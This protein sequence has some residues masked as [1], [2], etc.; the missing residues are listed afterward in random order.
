MICQYEVNMVVDSITL[1]LFVVYSPLLSEC[2]ID[3]FHMGLGT[4]WYFMVLLGTTNKLSIKWIPCLHFKLHGEFHSYFLF[5]MSIWWP[6]YNMK[7]SEEPC[8]KWKDLW[9]SILFALLTLPS[10]AFYKE[11]LLCWLQREIFRKNIV[12]RICCVIYIFSFVHLMLAVVHGHRSTQPNKAE[13][14]MTSKWSQRNTTNKIHDLYLVPIYIY[15]LKQAEIIQFM[16]NIIET[17]QSPVV[18][19]ILF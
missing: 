11:L 14:Y 17:L 15:Q 10:T 8:F 4:L 12:W 2:S 13:Y 6:F 16:A 7:L 9:S 3:V 1:S 18:Q 5:R 19:L